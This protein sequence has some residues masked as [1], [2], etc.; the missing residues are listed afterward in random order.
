MRFAGIG[1]LLS[2]AGLAFTLHNL[3]LDDI[4]AAGKKNKIQLDA[5]PGSNEQFLGRDVHI[6]GER[7]VAEGKDEVELVQ[8]GSGSVPYFPRT[9]SLPASE[10]SASSPL[11]A[12]IDTEDEYTLVGLGIRTV[13]IFGI[14]VSQTS[15]ASPHTPPCNNQE[16]AV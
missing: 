8:T 2:V 11:I 14:E 1:L 6:I 15:H 9:L 10:P 5:T 12:G 4:E 7:V 16:S 3:D 13:S